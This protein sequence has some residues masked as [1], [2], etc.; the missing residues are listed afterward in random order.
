MPGPRND[1][2]EAETPLRALKTL[3]VGLVV[4]VNQNEIA[5]DSIDCI[6]YLVPALDS[7]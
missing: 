2:A 7:R 3:Q 5:S 4:D 6:E 1:Y